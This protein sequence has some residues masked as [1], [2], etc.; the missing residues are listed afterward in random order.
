[1]SKILVV[2]DSLSTL[3]IAEGV[4]N[5]AGHEVRTCAGGR[6]EMIGRET[7]DLVLTDLFMP[8]RDGLEIIAQGRQ[9]RPGMPIVAM[10]GVTGTLSML[11]AAKLM[12]ACQLLKKPFS[13][14][15]LLAVVDR[16]LS[17]PQKDRGVRE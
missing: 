12:G 2:D 1:M 15:A 10:S 11:R 13:G 3:E 16:A 6:E 17:K 5:A 8:E 7:F 4:L 9:A 14:A